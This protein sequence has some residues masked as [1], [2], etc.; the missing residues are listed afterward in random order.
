MDRA[1]AGFAVA[2]IAASL[3]ALS[4]DERNIL[5]ALGIVLGLLALWM[6]FSSG[7]RV[8]VRHLRMEPFGDDSWQ[9]DVL[10]SVKTARKLQ[11]DFRLELS[12]GSLVE[13]G[14]WNEARTV[15]PTRYPDALYLSFNPK[16]FLAGATDKRVV[17]I[18]D[19][20]QPE[21]DL[22]LTYETLAGVWP[23]IEHRLGIPGSA[24]H[25]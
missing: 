19:G 15:E 23:K 25:F 6:I 24:T 18:G 22:Y 2:A 12:D 3:L 17:F 8:G 16:W 14:R 5:V 20:P 9:A 13:G 4:T 10:L 7:L 11:I 1:T 21:G